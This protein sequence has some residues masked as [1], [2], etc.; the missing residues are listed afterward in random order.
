MSTRIDKNAKIR[1]KDKR[2]VGDKRKSA[3]NSVEVQI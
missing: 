3:S 2:K 1:I